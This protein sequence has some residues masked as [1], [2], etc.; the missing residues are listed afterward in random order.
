MS[1]PVHVLLLVTG[2]VT[3]A[4]MWAHLCSQS[5]RQR[6]L[7][8]P[9]QRKLHPQGRVPLPS[10]ARAASAGD[11]ARATTNNPNSC[12]HGYSNWVNHA[13]LDLPLIFLKNTG[14]HDPANNPE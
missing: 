11:P 13:L 1:E 3:G 12:R 10:P 6:E 5:L 9:G 7:C 14:K 8:W 2:V 4:R